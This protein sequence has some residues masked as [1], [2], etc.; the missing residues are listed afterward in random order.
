LAVERARARVAE[1]GLTNVE[2][3]HRRAE[4]LPEGSDYSLV[5]TMSIRRRGVKQFGVQMLDKS[6]SI[7]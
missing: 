5:L 2:I 1:A 3:V 4:E 6:A 7:C